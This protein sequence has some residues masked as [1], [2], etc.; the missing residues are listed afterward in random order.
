MRINN[1]NK[2]MIT[3]VENTRKLYVPLEAKLIESTS[4]L[5]FLNQ[6]NLAIYKN[7]ITIRN[8]SSNEHNVF[9]GLSIRFQIYANNNLNRI[10]C[11]NAIF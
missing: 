6:I 5:T 9:F 2:I 8:Y 10:N 3:M 7:N 1:T 11:T 4:F